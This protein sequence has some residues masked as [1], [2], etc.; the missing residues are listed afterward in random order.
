MVNGKAKGNAWERKSAKELSKSLTDGASEYAVWRSN[1][2]GGHSTI[3]AKK[4]AE[5]GYSSKQVGDLVATGSDFELVNQFFD[6]F[7]VECKALKDFSLMPPINKK[8]EDILKQ[9][10]EEIRISQGKSPLV[11]LKRNNKAIVVITTGDS[12]RLLYKYVSS[13]ES[14]IYEREEDKFY[15]IPYP[16][17]LD[18]ISGFL[19]SIQLL[20]ED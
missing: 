3:L 1:S 12:G 2:S 13:K 6:K 11:F 18:K 20:N 4:G 15:V 7:F 8:E 5:Q 19:K 14:L 16:L 9:V 10:L 17:L